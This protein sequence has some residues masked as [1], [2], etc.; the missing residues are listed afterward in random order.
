VSEAY[1]S[2]CNAY[3]RFIVGTSRLW[4]WFDRFWNILFPN[5]YNFNYY[6]GGITNLFLWV[7][8]LSGVLLFAYFVPNLQNAWATVNYLTGPEVPFG[9]VVRAIH[10]YGADGMMIA[11]LLHGFRVWWTDRYRKFRALAWLSGVILITFTLFIGITG[12]LLVWDQRSYLLS[13]EIVRMLRSLNSII[14]GVGSSLANFFQGGSLITDFTLTR[15][16]FFHIGLPFAL[17]FFLWMHYLRINRPVTYPPLLLNL[18]LIGT[19]L[20]CAGL[21]PF[22]SGSP[23]VVGQLPAKYEMDWLYMWPFWLMNFIG[24]GG[25]MAVMIIGFL[26]FYTQPWWWN[27]PYRNIPVVIDEK[28]TGCMF[29]MIDCHANAIY[30]IPTSG[31]KK[32]R[33][34][35]ARIHGAKC[36]E[37]GIC[38]GACPFQALELPMLRD[39]VIEEQITELCQK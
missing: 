37:C 24:P 23:A 1:V 12:Y 34:L 11:A 31:K 22:K 33:P 6:L 13:Q 8:M 29:C 28:C 39:R 30:M 35:L 10:R 36:A 38:V 2:F 5:Q 14:P 7:C 4:L 16:F 15:F 27:E 19:V 9:N 3:K 21:F 17:F 25:V 26:I 20:L 18:M 32:S